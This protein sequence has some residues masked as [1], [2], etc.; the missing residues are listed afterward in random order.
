[1]ATSNLVSIKS[2]IAWAHDDM[3]NK[4]ALSAKDFED[5]GLTE[6]AHTTWVEYNDELLEAASTYN[7]LA[8]SNKK[9][10]EKDLQVALGKVWAAW[11]Q[12]IKEGTEKDFNKNFFIRPSDATMMANVCALKTMDTA[13]GQQFT[14]QKSADFRRKVEIV[15]G[16]RM[17]G[18]AMLD[19]DKRDLI[20]AYE[21]AVK[22]IKNYTDA[23]EDGEDNKGNKTPGLKTLVIIAENA[24]KKEKA[25]CEKYK[26]SEEEI[27][28]RTAPLVKKVN[29]ANDAVKEANKKIA[30]ATKTK[31]AKEKDYNK[32]IALLKSVG[33]Y[34]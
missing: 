18:N 10:A 12:V 17:A 26:A 33:D 3:H 32:V 9:V 30:E 15:I 29:E 7:K 31:E 20:L 4:R 28:E 24:L 19:D 2:A 34:K 1:M 6:Q 21:G 5:Q 23:L 27:A 13:K 8:Q 22:T 16:I 14:N 25:F 11:R